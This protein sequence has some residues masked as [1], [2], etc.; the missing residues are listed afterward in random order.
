[1]HR[2]KGKWAPG[3]EGKGIWGVTASEY[4]V[5]FGGQSLSIQLTFSDKKPLKRK[6]KHR[7]WIK[8]PKHHGILSLRKGHKPGEPR[9]Q[10]R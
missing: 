1:M 7:F 8:I 6:K 9:W 2:K 3:V 10:R 5:S 4:G